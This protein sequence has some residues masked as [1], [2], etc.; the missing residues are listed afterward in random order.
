LGD[1][2][3][4]LQHAVFGL[5]GVG[6]AKVRVSAVYETAPVDY[7]AQPDF[8]NAV[9]LAQSDLAPEDLLD[10][11]LQ[12]ETRL[13]RSRAVPKGPRCVDIDLIAVGDETRDTPRLTLPHPRAGGRAFVL[14][15]WLELDPDAWLPGKGRVD[16]LLAGLDA[17]GVRRTSL[18]L[19]V[20]V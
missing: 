5:C 12:V 17:T 11:A 4:F 16:E 14:V 7:L 13:G 1:R 8:L 9:L 2:L 6:L 19:A 18:E 3:E 10:A 15:P 20:P